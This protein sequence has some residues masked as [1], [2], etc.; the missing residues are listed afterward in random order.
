MFELQKYVEEGKMC[1]IIMKWHP[2]MHFARGP[3][4]LL[5]EYI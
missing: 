5:L 4:G 3:R 2:M 1:K